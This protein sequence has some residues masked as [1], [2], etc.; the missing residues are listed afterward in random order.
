VKERN[1]GEGGAGALAGKGIKSLQP[2]KNR[3]VKTCIKNRRYTPTQ[4]NMRDTLKDDTVAH[5]KVKKTRKERWQKLQDDVL[6]RMSMM[7]GIHGYDYQHTC[8]D[9]IVLLDMRT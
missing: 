4:Q 3:G 7:M 2:E 5:R 9:G 6:C 1:L 8:K